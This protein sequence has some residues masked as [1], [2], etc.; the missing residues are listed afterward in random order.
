MNK[1]Y[2]IISILLISALILSS[3]STDDTVVSNL[4]SEIES[5]E[6]EIS[7]LEVEIEDLEGNVGILEGSLEE[8]NNLISEKD[9][10]INEL[11]S[12]IEVLSNSPSQSASLLSEAFTVLGY[13][14]NEDGAALSNHAH[15]TR[16]VRFSPYFNINENTDIIFYPGNTIGSNMFTNTTV[17]VW[18][19]YDGTGESIAG[20]YASYHSRFV[21]DEDYL[22]PELI[23]V[24][25]IVGTGNINNNIEDVYTNESYV[26]FHFTGFDPQFMGMDWRSLVLVFEEDN[27]DWYLVGVVHGEWTA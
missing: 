22:N 17:Y 19:E 8:K 5:A 9:N 20:E 18:G 23:G 6:N 13:L 10:T 16:G 15:P 1:K 25:S 24:N 3:C 7:S 2:F 4:E 27:G 11:S 14:A 12:E 21:Y 26:E